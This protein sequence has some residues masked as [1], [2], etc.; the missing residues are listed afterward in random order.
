VETKE[1]TAERREHS[2][3][4]NKD[5]IC[6]SG[7]KPVTDYMFKVANTDGD[8]KP[9]GSWSKDTGWIVSSVGTPAE[10]LAKELAN[11]QLKIGEAV[12]AF[13]EASKDP[14]AQGEDRLTLADAVKK[15]APDG[16]QGACEDLMEECRERANA[17]ITR[18]IQLDESRKARE[19]VEQVVEECNDAFN[20]ITTDIDNQ[21]KVGATKA[22]QLPQDVLEAAETY[23]ANLSAIDAEIKKFPKHP[24]GELLA[25]K[26]AWENQKLELEASGKKLAAA[27]DEAKEHVKYQIDWTTDPSAASKMI[28]TLK[29]AKGF[30]GDKV[31]G[32]AIGELIATLE[33]LKR[34]SVHWLKTDASLNRQETLRKL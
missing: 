11:V 33:A 20:K 4:G 12:K 19:A 21:H 15:A 3:Q 28:E 5:V 6:V 14:D 2:K 8:D 27:L 25:S 13:E 31:V 32:S 24:V 29:K 9:L 10:K 22:A 7:L 18:Q 1:I 16:A 23:G 17:A 26:A 34:K 30:V